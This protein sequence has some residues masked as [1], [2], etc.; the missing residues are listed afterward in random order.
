MK[1]FVWDGMRKVKNST[2]IKDFVSNGLRGSL[3]VNS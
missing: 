2:D 1:I 3:I